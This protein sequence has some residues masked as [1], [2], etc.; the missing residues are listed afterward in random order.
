MIIHCGILVKR[1]GY[2]RSGCEEDTGTKCEEGDSD[3]DC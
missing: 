3:T 1:M 2:I